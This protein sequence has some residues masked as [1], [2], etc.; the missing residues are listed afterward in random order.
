MSNHTYTCN[1]C[2]YSRRKLLCNPRTYETVYEPRDDG[3]LNG[4]VGLSFNFTTLSGLKRRI[5]RLFAPG[6]VTFDNYG[7]FISVQVMTGANDT[8]ITTALARAFRAGRC[9]LWE[10]TLCLSPNDGSL[11]GFR[12]DEG[13][14]DIPQDRAAMS[15]A[16]RSVNAIRKT[17]NQSN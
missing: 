3:Q 7:E 15:R 13:I 12:G 11:A 1:I 10:Y 9:C 14:A 2:L 4:Y 8:R 6:S 17:M 5:R 16:S